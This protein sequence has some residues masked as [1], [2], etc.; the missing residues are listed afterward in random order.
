MNDIAI[1]TGA[2]AL[3]GSLLAIGTFIGAIRSN[4]LTKSEC[5]ECRAEC[6]K[7]QSDKVDKVERLLSERIES[8]D[9]RYNDKTELLFDK[10]DQLTILITKSFE[11]IRLDLVKM[12]T[13]I[14][15]HEKR[16]EGK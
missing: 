8:V 5:K 1:Y 3:G 15:A 6:V 14:L 2:F 4:Y 7:A 16:L 10:I 12:Q 13:S 9:R 11:E